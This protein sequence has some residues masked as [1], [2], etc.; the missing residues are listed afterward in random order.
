MLAI[1]EHF[2]FF[3]MLLFEH[4]NEFDYLKLYMKS[5]ML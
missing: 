3:L 4:I 1:A 5:F 2:P